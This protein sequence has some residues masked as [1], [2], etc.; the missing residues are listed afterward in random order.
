MAQWLE[1][2]TAVTIK[3]GPFLDED[4]G[5]TAEVGLAIGQADIR[6]TKN[7]GN[8]AQSNNVAGAAHDEIGWYDVP[9][10]TTDT[11]TLGRLTVFIHE[12]GAL[13]VW[14]DFMI[15]PTNVWDSMFGA[16][17]LQVDAVEVSGDSGAADNLET[18]CDGGSYN[19]GGG[20]VVA[21]SVT[22]GVSLANDAITLAKFDETTAWPLVAADGGNTQVARVGADG[23][24]LETLSD[25]IDGAV[26]DIATVDGIVDDI[27]VDTAVIGALGAGLTAV[28]W[29]A[30]WDT[31]VQSEV[32]DALETNN[33]DH[34]LKVATV[35]ADM[36][37]E[38][39]DNT[40][41]SRMLAS[42]DTS[43][44]DPATDSLQ[45]IRDKLTD[46]ETDTNEL[47]TDDIPGA[48]A[49]LND[50][51]AAMIADAVWNELAAGHTDAGKAGEQLWTD[52]DAVLADTAELQTDD[53]P[54]AIAALNNIST[55]QVN[56][57]VDTALSDIDLDHLIQVT[58]GAEEPTDGSYLDQ[59][60]H[61]GAGQTFDAT[62]DSL[63]AIRD[64]LT[65]IEAD[66]NELQTDNIPGAI[67][68]LN[69][70]TAATIADAVWDEVAA[71]H[72]DAG[73]AGEQLWT[74][75]DAVLVD[76]NEL[77][78]DDTPAAIAALN[79]L[80]A[81]QVNAEVDTALADY[82]APT[83]AEMNA[84][85]AALNDLN[86]AQV[87]AEVVDAL[88]G[89]TYAEPP[90]GAPLATATLAAK[91]SYLYKAF[92]NRITQTATTLSIY[93]DAEAVVDQRAPVSDDGVT[94]TR[95]E[96]ISG[97]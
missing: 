75:L 72:V 33:L 40:I 50:P 96:I 16:D 13:P 9:L 84:G 67:A 94:Y 79:D 69:D 82:D 86:A 97:P 22:A 26:A 71:G 62:T 12:A 83:D 43:V 81:A 18:A 27:L 11:N 56:T 14:Q 58:A 95:G 87:N 59:I 29:N 78:T 90:Q 8:A 92:R 42:G 15:V 65:D 73:K 80:T 63:E 60:M 4:D 19:V 37:A 23:D 39:V 24:T 85:F 70:P 21:A 49:G 36:T 54:G 76:T 52:L 45:D 74:D 55:A 53:I 1:Q 17:K 31:E 44:F 41:L 28:P 10:D 64:K 66:T 93:N 30:N 2:S 5:K 47:Q 91:I 57:E 20:G 35:G 3:M 88:N 77:Q 46:I 61:K 38:V 34:L 89:D 48:I 6:L 32:Q 25:Q 68:A 7:G 51:T